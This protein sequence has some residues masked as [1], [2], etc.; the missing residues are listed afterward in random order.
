MR[1]DYKYID[2]DYAYTDP[3]TGIL[4]NLGGN[5]DRNTLAFTEIS[6]AS[7]RAEELETKPI[8]IKDS[9]ALFA[10]HRHLFQDIY[11]WVGKTRT[12][13]ISKGDNRFFPM[14]HFHNAL[15][16]IDSLIAERLRLAKEDKA[17]LFKE[18]CRDPR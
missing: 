2:P 7:K 9:S 13:E 16:Y 5:T 4:R 18:T 10:I 14:S 11:D 17:G 8:R 15:K 1:N 12:V 6:I 3:K